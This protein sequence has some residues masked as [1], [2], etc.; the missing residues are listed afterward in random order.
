MWENFSALRRARTLTL[1]LNTSGQLWLQGSMG[2]GQGMPRRQRNV[3]WGSGAPSCLHW[4]PLP[5]QPLT[6]GLTCSPAEPAPRATC[7][8]WTW[9]PGSAGSWLTRTWGSASCS[10][11]FLLHSPHWKTEQRDQA[12]FKQLSPFQRLNDSGGMKAVHFSV[13][14]TQFQFQAYYL[15]VIF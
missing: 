15:E 8:L 10:L 1:T 2:R 11:S 13:W 9:P 14:T 7:P 5:W 12:S 6:A 3:T 4:L